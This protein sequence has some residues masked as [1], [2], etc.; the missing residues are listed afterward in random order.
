MQIPD[1]PAL[2]DMKDNLIPEASY[3][4]RCVKADY[5]ATP[6]STDAKGPYI[7]ARFVITGPDSAEK[8]KGRIVFQNMSLDSS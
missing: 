5:V 3:N 8:Q 6:K 7:N 4:V 1:A 2:K